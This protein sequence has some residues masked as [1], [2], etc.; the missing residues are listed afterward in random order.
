[1][2]AHALDTDQAKTIGIVVIIAVVLIGA[3]VSAIITALIGRI[4]VIVV[5]LLIAA[6]VWTQRSSISSAAK[7]C[8]A[9]FFG[10]H[11]TPSNPTLKQHCQDIS[12]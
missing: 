3:V 6:F 1:V 12:R 8:D 11:L 7:N 9:S 5:V 10:I 2:A 4:V